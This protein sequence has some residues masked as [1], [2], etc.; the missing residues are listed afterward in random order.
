MMIMATV[1]HD[2][3]FGQEKPGLRFASSAPSRLH[4]PKSLQQTTTFMLPA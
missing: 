3:H 2:H 1:G 4:R